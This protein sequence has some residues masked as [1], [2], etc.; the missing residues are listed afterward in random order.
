LESIHEFNLERFVNHLGYVS[1]EVALQ[2]QRCSQVL[3]LIEIDSEQTNCIIPGKLFEYLVSERPILAIG[4]EQ[5]DFA[6]IIKETNT[7]TFFTYNNQEEVKAQILAYFELF[8]RQELVV[9]AVGLQKYSRRALTQD[10]VRL[11]N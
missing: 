7:G 9:N 11:L 3:L 2:E 10:L 6:S 1:H 8:L 5:A 4:P